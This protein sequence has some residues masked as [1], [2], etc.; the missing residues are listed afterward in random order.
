M[1]R[2][3]LSDDK[4]EG[5]KIILLADA[6]VGDFVEDLRGRGRCVAEVLEVLK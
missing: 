2:N 5:V 3:P 6:G 1:S 4:D